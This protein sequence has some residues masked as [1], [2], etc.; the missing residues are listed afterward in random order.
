MSA[1]PKTKCLN[2][3]CVWRNRNKMCL[4]REYEKCEYHN[5]DWFKQLAERYPDTL[6]KMSMQELLE[7][8]FAYEDKPV[9]TWE[10][11]KGYI[12]LLPDNPFAV[13]YETARKK[14]CE[15]MTKGD[16]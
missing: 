2:W 10:E 3:I 11:S 6:T 4:T 7:L 1:Q 9:P 13:L 8:C 14:E 5:A 12:H 15:F 16:W